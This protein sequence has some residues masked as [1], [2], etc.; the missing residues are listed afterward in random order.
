MLLTMTQP[1]LFSEVDVS[2]A[3]HF[4]GFAGAI[5]RSPQLGHRIKKLTLNINSMMN[6][7]KGSQE[8]VGLCTL[9]LEKLTAQRTGWARVLCDWISNVQKLGISHIVA[10]LL[11]QTANLELL[12][13]V[14]AVSHLPP[15]VFLARN[16]EEYLNSLKWLILD[17]RPAVSLADVSPL[18]YLARLQ[19]FSCWGCVGNNQTTEDDPGSSFQRSQRAPNI[20]ILKLKECCM[21]ERSITELVKCCP[22][23]NTVIYETTYFPDKDFT[24]FAPNRLSEVL[25][26]HH[27][28]LDWLELHLDFLDIDDRG[29]ELSRTSSPWGQFSKLEYLEIDQIYLREDHDLPPNLRVL[30]LCNCINPIFNFLRHI[31]NKTT[32]TLLYLEIINLMLPEDPCVSVLGISL[33]TATEE[34][35]RETCQL[36]TQILG[37]T[38]VDIF[39]S[40]D[41]WKK[42]QKH[43]EIVNW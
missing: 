38:K 27:D 21:D 26:S 4:L 28:Q 25:S 42:V 5:F 37:A 16:S 14:A 6:G 30:V 13:L 39:F 17:G 8:K 10:L 3:A 31:A 22:R 12:C 23:L 7:E 33:F 32:S 11:T 41:V 1:S 19:E 2:E 43:R 35:V 20:S 29:L 36:I 15:I 40:E 18:L 24:N 9:A 34:L